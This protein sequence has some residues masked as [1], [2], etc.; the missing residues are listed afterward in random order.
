MFRVCVPLVDVFLR[1]LLLSTSDSYIYYI[2]I[3][4]NPAS[5]LCLKL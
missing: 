2:N 3:S 1:H 5:L 4:F